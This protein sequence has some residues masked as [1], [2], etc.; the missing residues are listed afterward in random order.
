MLV[1]IETPDSILF[2]EPFLFEHV[3]NLLLI[4]YLIVADNK[5]LIHAHRLIQL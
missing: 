2:L 1:C 4:R 5:T 3:Q